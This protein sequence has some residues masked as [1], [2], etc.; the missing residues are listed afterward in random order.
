MTDYVSQH[1]SLYNKAYYDH[2]NNV[3]YNDLQ[4][5]NSDQSNSDTGYE[6]YNTGNGN[7]DTSHDENNSSHDSG[8]AYL[9]KLFN[10]KPG[11]Q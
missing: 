8:S 7:Y 4:Q 6:N 5:T 11:S 2:Q 9:R 3:G 10:G 1:I